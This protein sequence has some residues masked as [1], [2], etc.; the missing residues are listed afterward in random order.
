MGILRGNT[1]LLFE[2][3]KRRPFSGAILELSRALVF[4]TLP[5]VQQIARHVGVEPSSVPK[6]LPSHDP[7]LAALDC[8]DDHTLFRM[9]GFTDVAS[10]DISAYEGAEYIADLNRPFPPELHDRF[11]VVFDAGTLQH[12]F[13]IPQALANMHRAVRVGGR[14]II[15]MGAS[16][17]HVDHGFYMFSP[18]LFYDYFAANNY[19]IDTARVLEF[20]HTWLA[21]R[22]YTSRW[23]VYDYTPGCLDHLSYGG[24][25]HRQVALF[26]VATRKPESTGELAPQQSYFQ[27]VWER[28]ADTLHHVPARDEGMVTRFTTRLEKQLTKWVGKHSLLLSILLFVKHV[29]HAWRGPRPHRPPLVDRY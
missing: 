22:L 6:V 5:E 9:M 26:F 24:F 13:D 28:P 15:G 19:E 20:T 1:R 4:L 3:H 8:I 10:V 21:G 25:G 27:R 12:V 11:D 16:H 14:I 18:T 17:N 29:A 7:R 2:E 23:R